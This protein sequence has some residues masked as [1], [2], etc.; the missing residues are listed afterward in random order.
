MKDE[1]A[2]SSG[3]VTGRDGTRKPFPPGPV[4][5]LCASP[6]AGSLVLPMGWP[7]S[8]QSCSVSVVRFVG[9]VRGMP[10]E[11][12]ATGCCSLLIKILQGRFD[13]S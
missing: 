8:A 9:R 4:V 2:Y 5:W 12:A 10:L 1:E 7:A 6:I 13:V 11:C 3:G